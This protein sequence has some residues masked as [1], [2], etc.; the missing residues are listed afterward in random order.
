MKLK[1]TF[2]VALIFL[3]LC[4]NALALDFGTNITKYDRESTTTD[5]SSW[6]GPQEDQEVE[7]GNQTGQIWDLEGF[8]LKGSEL[9]IVAGFNLTGGVAGDSHSGSDG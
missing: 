7:P 4:G 8:F 5:T 3:F 9:A 6:Y 1:T 2:L